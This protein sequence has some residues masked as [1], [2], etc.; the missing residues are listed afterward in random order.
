MKSKI[1]ASIVIVHYLRR[2]PRAGDSQV[3][4]HYV[5]KYADDVALQMQQTTSR[6]EPFATVHE[7]VVGASKSTDSVGATESDEITGR[8]QDM[9]AKGTPHVRRWIDLRDFD[10]FDYIDSFDKLKILSDPTNKYV[11]LAVSA[12]NRKKDRLIA[13]ACFGSVREQVGA[14]NGA[15]SQ[16]VALPAAQKVVHGGTNISMAKIRTGIQLMNANEAA[17]PEEGGE[18]VFVYTAEQLT[19][20]MADATLTS[21]DYNSLRALQN[22]QVDMFMGMKWVRTELLP[23]T[24]TTRSCGIFGKGYIHLGVGLNIKNDISED[25]GKRGHPIRV[26]SMMSLGA[27]RS[28]D[29]GVVEIQCTEAA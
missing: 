4:N 24:G 20:L 18:R 10:W 14:G 21:A 26:Y 25:K 11:T 28:E 13:E 6:L 3:L 8:F 2:D 19:V 27:A 1:L 17:S 22:F 5:N 29:K 15:V 12:H 7:G 16:Y 23:K 9:Q